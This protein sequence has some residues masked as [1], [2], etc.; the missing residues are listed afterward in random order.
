MYW[1]LR[2]NTIWQWSLP[3]RATLNINQSLDEGLNKDEQVEKAGQP[4]PL[5]K[6]LTRLEAEQ[7][8]MQAIETELQKQYTTRAD[9]ILAAPPGLNLEGTLFDFCRTVNVIE[10]KS[11]RRIKKR[12]RRGFFANASRF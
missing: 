11:E 6:V 2:I 4:D 3:G 7:L 1:K 12:N 5:F 9:L 8:G 10:F